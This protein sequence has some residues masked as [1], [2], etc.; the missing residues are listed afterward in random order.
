MKQ[1][2][3]QNECVVIHH[4]DDTGR[5]VNGKIC[6]VTARHAE[7]DFYIVEPE[8]NDIFHKE[9]S[10]FSIIESCLKRLQ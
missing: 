2:F 9:F 4:F 7:F 10:H 5:E 6:G 8:S 3:K 1:N